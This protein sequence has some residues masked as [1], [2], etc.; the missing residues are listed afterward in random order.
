MNSEH[1]NDVIAMK[2]VTEFKDLSLLENV[3]NLLWDEGPGLIAICTDHDS[4]NQGRHYCFQQIGPLQIGKPKGSNSP[5]QESKLKTGLLSKTRS[6]AAWDFKVKNNWKKVEQQLE[7]VDR[8][9]HFTSHHHHIKVTLWQ[10]CQGNGPEFGSL[11]G[12][13]NKKLLASMNDQEKQDKLVHRWAKDVI[14]VVLKLSKRAKSEELYMNSTPFVRSRKLTQTVFRSMPFQIVVAILITANFIIN[15]IES[16][17]NGKLVDEYG[18]PN[19]MQDVLDLVDTVMTYA[20]TFELLINMY[21]H[22]WVEFINDGWSVFDF[23]IVLISLISQFSPQMKN[24]SIF[25]LLRAFRVLRIFG[26]LKSIRSIINALTA[27]IIPVL[28]AFFI[29][30]IVL[31]LFAIIGVT[32]FAEE[33]PEEFGNLSR[34]TIT[35]FRIAGGETW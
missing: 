5:R 19:A 26:R 27:S 31:V 35:M 32:F 15:A 3:T 1:F 20:F 14:E 8:T 23:C 25:R 17:Y 7:C 29:M 18:N 10:E 13:I 28:N 12:P 30:A 16:Q 24:V 9:G 11:I 4:Y 33:A 22:L 21:A 34:S 6:R 2:D